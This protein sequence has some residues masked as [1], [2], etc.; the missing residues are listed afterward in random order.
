MNLPGVY[1]GPA[2]SAKPLGPVLELSSLKAR[3]AGSAAERAAVHAVGRWFEERGEAARYDGFV[4][5]TS[6]PLNVTLH[7]LVAALGALVGALWAPVG[8]ALVALAMSSAVIE[9]R[10]G[11]RVLRRLLPRDTSYNLVV[12]R[13]AAARRLGTLV[14]A[15]HVDVP[16]R[17]WRMNRRLAAIPLGAAAALA[18]VLALESVGVGWFWLPGLRL[19]LAGGLFFGAAIAL[20]HH[21]RPAR[22]GVG[23]GDSGV[24]A[25]MEASLALG[26][27][28]LQHLDVIF[29][30]VGCQEAHGGGVRALL[31]EERTRLLPADT[32]LVFVEDVGVGELI[33][34]VGEAVIDTVSYR[35]TLPGIAERVTRQLPWREV[36]GAVLKGM[37]GALQPT[38]QG[39][40]AMTI[41]GGGPRGGP[42]V[43]GRVRKCAAF[44]AE[45]A[46]VYDADLGEAP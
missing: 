37:T 21:T 12:K 39:Y 42:V 5:A 41:T 14:L 6:P 32:A 15:A 28:P 2:M 8:L 1:L 3:L 7:L 36:G 30:V 24:A 20:F 44:L 46:W 26:E 45:V 10:G 18:L 9:L 19:A 31:R 38:R 29:A 22:E 17:T 35:P 43:A 13:P 4:A 34:G 16:R 33:Y 25:V 23:P 11:R 40:R 27:R